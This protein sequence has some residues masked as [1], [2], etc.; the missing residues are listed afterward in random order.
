MTCAV[1]P[2]VAGELGR[3]GTGADRCCPLRSGQ[4]WP[5]CGPDVAHPPRVW[6]ARPASKTWLRRGGNGRTLDRGVRPRLGARL[7]CRQAPHRARGS[8]L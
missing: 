4:S 2:E 5:E 6:R 7:A 3:R 1:W 8:G